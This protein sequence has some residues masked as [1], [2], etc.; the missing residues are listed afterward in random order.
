MKEASCEKTKS[1]GKEHGSESSADATSI[2]AGTRPTRKQK[3]SM[4]EVQE[5]NC[6]KGNACAYWHPLECS[7]YKTRAEGSITFIR[8]MTL[9]TKENSVFT[10][11]K[12]CDAQEL[13]MVSRGDRGRL[14]PMLKTTRELSNNRGHVEPKMERFLRRRHQISTP[15]FAERGQE[16]TLYFEE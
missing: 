4:Y 6:Q 13:N 3:N 1:A 11:V 5:R 10:V 12:I 14:R 7:F 2:P 9:R 8:T 15:T 16:W